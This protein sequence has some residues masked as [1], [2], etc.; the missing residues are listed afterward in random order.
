MPIP[1]ILKLPDVESATHLSRSSVYR[2]AAQGSFPKP[3]RL[4]SR[5]VGW[6]G[7]EITAWIEARTAER[8]SDSASADSPRPA[9]T[10]EARQ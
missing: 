2:L 10:T 5:A 6:R 3:L 9:D 8:N 7:D 1:T 4:G